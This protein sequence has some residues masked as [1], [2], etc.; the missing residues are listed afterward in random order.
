MGK[1]IVTPAAGD[2]TL[3]IGAC[4]HSMHF[5]NLGNKKIKLSPIENMYLGYKN[6]SYDIE[7]YIKK[8]KFDKK[9]KIKVINP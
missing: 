4:Y 8:N 1:I 5:K 6:N 9:F 3:S 7:N 2:S